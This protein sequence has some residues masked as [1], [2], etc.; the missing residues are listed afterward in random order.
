[1]AAAEATRIPL[2]V[3]VDPADSDTRPDRLREAVASSPATPKA[4]VSVT[5]GHGWDLVTTNGPGGESVTPVGERI[6]RWIQGD[7]S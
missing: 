4:F 5:G 3:A 6:L 7:Y 1:M 2:L